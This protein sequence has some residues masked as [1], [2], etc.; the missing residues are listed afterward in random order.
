MRSVGL[1][2]LL[3]MSLPCAADDFR[4]AAFGSTR[5]EVRASEDGVEWVEHEQGLAF[6]TQISG[7]DAHAVYIFAGD[8]FVRGTYLITERH[9]NKTAHISDFDNIANLL[10]LK[11]GEPDEGDSIWLNDLYKDSPEDW[12]MALSV[13]HLAMFR[14]WKISQ[15]GI[16]MLL[17]GDNY[18]VT[19]QIDYDSAEWGHLEQEAKEKQALDAL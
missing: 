13:G 1:V 14:R 3:S 7:I 9:A 10:V 6:E 2:I 5:D 12:G 17:S 16:T 8:V 15:G 18:Q 4:S 11:Y 19:F